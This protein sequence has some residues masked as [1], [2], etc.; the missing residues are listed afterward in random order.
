MTRS[1]LLASA[2]AVCLSLGLAGSAIADQTRFDG[3][4]NLPFEQN[5]PTPETAK[6]LMEELEFQRRPRPICGRCR[7]STRLA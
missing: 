7:S 3:L 6:T 2:A 1:I 5:V 4:A